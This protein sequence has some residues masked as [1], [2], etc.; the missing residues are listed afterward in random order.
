MTA[1]L[2]RCLADAELSFTQFVMLSL[3]DDGSACTPGE[4]AREAGMTSGAVTRQL[5]VL[6]RRKLLRR[7]RD[8]FDRRRVDLVITAEGDSAVQAAVPW[9]AAVWAKVLTAFTTEETEQLLDLLLRLN[10]AA[11]TFGNRPL[12]ESPLISDRDAVRR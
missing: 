8:A 11:E 2:T 4:I 12:S 5:D 3:I 6:E 1:N 7:E 10:N 9:I